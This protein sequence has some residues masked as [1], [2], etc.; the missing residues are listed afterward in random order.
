MGGDG[1]FSWAVDRPVPEALRRRRR[2]Q[3]GLVADRELVVRRR[4]VRDT[5]IEGDLGGGGGRRPLRSGRHVPQAQ[6]EHYICPS[7]LTEM[8]THLESD[9]N[10]ITWPHRLLMQGPDTVGLSVSHVHDTL[11]VN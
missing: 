1:L 8:P 2:P 3:R 10:D 4:L 5:V 6:M 7:Q 11:D 9:I